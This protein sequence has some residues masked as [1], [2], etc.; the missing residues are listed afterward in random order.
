MT[1]G[2]HRRYR[3]IKAR[4]VSRLRDRR[5]DPRIIRVCQSEITGHEAIGHGAFLRLSTID[6]SK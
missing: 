6:Q 2:Q 3:E 5:L 1:V 4:K